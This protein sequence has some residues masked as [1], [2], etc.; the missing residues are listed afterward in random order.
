MSSPTAD[1]PDHVTPGPEPGSDPGAEPAAAFEKPEQPEEPEQPGELAEPGQLAEPEQLAEP[2]QPEAAD[3]A[4]QPEELAEPEQPEAAEAVEQPVTGQAAVPGGSG[5]DAVGSRARRRRLVRN[6]TALTVAAAAVAGVIVA[7]TG[8]PASTP[9]GKGTAT[10]GPATTGTAGTGTGGPAVLAEEAAATVAVVK[11][12]GSITGGPV[13]GPKDQLWLLEASQATGQPMLAVVNP[14]TYAVSTR[15]LPSTIDGISLRYTGAEAFDNV[16]QLWLVAQATTA[17]AG[18]QPGGVLVRYLPGTGATAQFSLDGTCDPVK[19]PAQLFTASDG[20]VWVECASADSGATSI[21]RLQRNGAFIQPSIVTPLNRALRGT[22]MWDV[23][24]NLPQA[25]IGPLAPAAGGAMWGMTTGGL[26]QISATGA[27][28]F[29][30]SDQY[31]VELVTQDWTTV[32]SL[33]LVGNGLSPSVEGIGDCRPARAPA[34]QAQECAVLVNS[35]GGKAMLAAAPDHDG[36]VGSPT[37]HPPGIDQSGDV[38]F[39]VD[40]TAGG[41]APA[42]QYFFEVTSGGGTRLIPFSVPHDA[43]P[44]PV[45]QPPVITANGAVWTADPEAGPGALVEVMPKD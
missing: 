41:K 36:H 9:A 22:P 2:G 30:P 7:F 42:G 15:P 44:I 6:M 10:T 21:V 25:K 13:L 20:G 31:A 35:V 32:G 12:S 40:G 27:E 11:T 29:A 26:V 38:W 3:E 19:P 14:A 28:T 45:G 18:Q 37:V 1:A 23:F 17:T 24:A 39:I 16:G 5:D 8:I 43:H 33:Q 34:S 4:A